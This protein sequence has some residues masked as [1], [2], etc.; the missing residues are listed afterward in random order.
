M[1]VL[2][3]VGRDSYDVSWRSRARFDMGGDDSPPQA[4]STTDSSPWGELQPYLKKGFT[5]AETLLN[6]DK[7]EFYENSTVVPFSNQTQS[8]LDMQE[9]RAMSGSPLNMGAQEETMKN[10]S[11]QYLDQANPAFK[12]MVE[13]SV[14]PLRE[15]YQNVVT[16]GIE[17]RFQQ[18]GRSN[19]GIAETLA[20]KSTADSYG[21]AV[22]D[23]TSGLAYKDYGDERNRMLQAAGMAPSLANTDYQDIAQLGQ[24]GAIREGKA[25]EVLKDDMAR[26][27]FEQNIEAKKLRDY[28][29][30]IAG[31]SFGGSSSTS[32]PM[33]GSNPWLTGAG[34]V[35]TGVGAANT[36]FNPKF[37][38]MS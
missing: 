29:T 38:L 3:P 10:L 2:N 7:P 28:M 33:T 34:L 37:G 11:G 31:G 15:E 9:F 6:S 12:G 4:I 36:L 8:A 20:K 22:G 32:S 21:R 1:S 24:V 25:G 35:S 26:W 13:R 23:I 17:S 19:S 5:Q 18:A 27:D 16:P 30:A 14:A